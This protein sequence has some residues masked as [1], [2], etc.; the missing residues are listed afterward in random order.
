M[1]IVDNAVLNAD[2]GQMLLSA[3]VD[4]VGD[5]GLHG[6][7][8]AYYGDAGVVDHTDKVAAMTAI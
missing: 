4:S 5:Q 3:G 7:A 8:A 2:D 6:L 1:F